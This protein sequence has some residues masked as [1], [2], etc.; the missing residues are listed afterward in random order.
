LRIGF[1]DFA[2]KAQA[3]DLL[4]IY[5]AGRAMHDP[6]P[7]SNDKMYLAPFGTQMKAMDSTAISFSDLDMWLDQSIHCN[8][9]FIIFDVGHEVEGDWKY[10]GPNLVNN[11]LLSLFSEQKGRAILTSGSA[12]E[13]SL[14]RPGG[15]SSF[16]YWL[17]RGLSGEADLNQDRVVT[18]DELFR[19]VEEKVREDSVGKQIPRFRLPK[20]DANQPVGEIAAAK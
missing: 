10:P 2:A 11:H 5:V 3:N 12:G 18:A 16:T 7:G 13:V 15:Q 19:F 14:A 1:S 8:H 6:Q 17:T 20:S 9:T 4:V